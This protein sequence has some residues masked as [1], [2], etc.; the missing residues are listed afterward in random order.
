ME[1]IKQSISAV[2]SDAGPLIH[3]DEM[4]CLSALN[5][6]EILVPETVWQEVLK[7]RPQVFQY[8]GI[9]LQRCGINELPTRITAIAPLFGLHRGELEALS[10]CLQAPNALLLTDDGAARLAADSL[11]ITTHGTIGLEMF[12]KSYKYISHNCYS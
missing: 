7:H 9:N 2:V 11:N 10:L 12:P 5:F 1:K 3:L 4:D 6:S 8:A